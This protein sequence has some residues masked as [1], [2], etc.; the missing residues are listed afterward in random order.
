MNWSTLTSIPWHELV[1]FAS[2]CGIVWK[3]GSKVIKSVEHVSAQMVPNGGSSIRDAIDR[4]ENGVAFSERRSRIAYDQPDKPRG[5]FELDATGNC[6]FASPKWCSLHGANV[7]DA[8]GT[9]WL[10]FVD[11]GE[12]FDIQDSL[13]ASISGSRAFVCR[14]LGANGV[15]FRLHA[16]RVTRGPVL[17]GFIGFVEQAV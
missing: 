5:Y 3:I 13:T 15:R 7:E 12:R 1:A 6:T 2:V 11:D 14:Y 9:G 16:D 17:V 8:L 4:I 10:N